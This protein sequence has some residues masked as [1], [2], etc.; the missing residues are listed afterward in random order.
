MGKWV[1]VSADRH[2]GGPIASCFFLLLGCGQEQPRAGGGHC[3]WGKPRAVGFHPR[4]KQGKALIFGYH[5]RVLGRSV[6]NSELR[7]GR[8]RACKRSLAMMGISGAQGWQPGQG[9]VG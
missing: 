5:K 9:L 8:Q 4:P 6:M 7:A 2:E 3:A 1:E